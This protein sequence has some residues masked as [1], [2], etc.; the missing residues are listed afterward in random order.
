MDEIRQWAL[1]LIIGSLAGTVVIAVSPRGSTDKTVKAVVGIFVVAAICTP[2]A[3][4]LKS[5]L[6]VYALADYEYES[7]KNSDSINEYMISVCQ[8]TVNTHTYRIAEDMEITVR[9]ICID[10]NIDSNNCMIIHDVTVTVAEE[11]KDKS[12]EFSRELSNALGVSV[13]VNA[14]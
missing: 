8:D 9:E 12:Q 10:M 1:C 6:S 4:I 13:T 11:N 2:L 14:E 3:N 5:D 7:E